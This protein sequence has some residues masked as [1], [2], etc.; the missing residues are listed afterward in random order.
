MMNRI[1]ANRWSWVLMIASWLG[2]W[3]GAW[4]RHVAWN[5]PLTPHR[6]VASHQWD[7]YGRHSLPDDAQHC[8][9]CATSAH[10]N[11]VFFFSGGAVPAL[12]PVGDSPSDESI[13]LLSGARFSPDQRGPPPAA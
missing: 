2:W 13:A 9:I 11:A 10:R 5:A 3:A 8:P 6:T 1:A 12:A 4:H 7:R